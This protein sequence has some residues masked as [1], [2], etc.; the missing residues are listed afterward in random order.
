MVRIIGTTC[1][2]KIRSFFV[3]LFCKEINRRI[4]Y[5]LSNR[6]R[7][8][9]SVLLKQISRRL[10]TL[11]T[12][13]L[14][15]NIVLLSLCFSAFPVT[16]AAIAATNADAN[17]VN[18]ATGDVS[19]PVNLAT[20]PGRNGLGFGI[21]LFYT[22]NVKNIVDSWNLETPTGMAGLGWTLARD[23]IIRNTNG[24]GTFEDDDFYLLDQSGLNHFVQTNCQ[25]TN[26][27]NSCDLFFY[28]AVK[29]N[30]W[31]IE[32]NSLQEQWT[33]IKE[34]GFK[35]I[36]GGGVTADGDG[37][38]TSRGDSV[39]WNIKWNNWIGNSIQ[40][41]NQ[42]QYA[43]SWNLVAIENSW[44]DQITFSY[45]QEQELVG[46]NGAQRRKYTRSIRLKDLTDPTGHK[47]I[48]HYLDKFPD[49]YEDPHTVPNG[50]HNQKSLPVTLHSS[51]NWDSNCNDTSKWYCKSSKAD[52]IVSV[53]VN[54]VAQPQCD[55]HKDDTNDVSYSCQLHFDSPETLN[56]VRVKVIDDDQGSNEQMFDHTF[57]DV[58]CASE[59]QICTQIDGEGNCTTADPKRKYATVKLEYACTNNIA[60]PDAYQE[61]Y[62][63]HYL[64]NVK[65]YNGNEHLYTTHLNY[66]SQ[67]NILPALLGKGKFAKRLLTGISYTAPDG[68]QYAP[69]QRFSYWGQKE[70]DGVKGVKQD[71]NWQWQY[72]LFN[73]Q[74]GA[75]YGALKTVTLP[76]G[77]EIT[78]FYNQQDIPKSK[79]K[80]TIQ[81]PSLPGTWSNPRLFW[82]PDYVV[83]I[84]QKEGTQEA[85]LS[86]Y[87]WLGYWK[88]WVL[89]DQGLGAGIFSVKD[90]N[91]V[92]GGVEADFFALTTSNGIFLFHKDMLIP[93][94]WQQQN[95]ERKTLVLNNIQVASGKRFFVV[96]NEL[97]HTVYRFTWTGQSFVEDSIQ[98]SKDHT[99]FGLTSRNNYFF[100]ASANPLNDSDPELRLYSLSSQGSWQESKETVSSQFF[101]GLSDPSKS[102]TKASINLTS[103]NSFLTLQAASQ[104]ETTIN[105]ATP[106]RAELYKHY[107]SSWS[108]NYKITIQ[109][110]QS[111]RDFYRPEFNEAPAPIFTT[112]GNNLVTLADQE[113]PWIIGTHDRKDKKYTY[114]FNGSN[115]LNHEFTNDRISNNFW[116]Y[117]SI[118]TTKNGEAQYREFNPDTESWRNELPKYKDGN[119]TL[120]QKA[121]TI[122]SDV[123]TVLSMVLSEVPVVGEVMMAADL[124]F[125]VGDMGVDSLAR[126]SSL[127]GIGRYFTGDNEAYY[128]LP[129]GTWKDLGPLAKEFQN[130]ETSCKGLACVRR[131]ETQELYNQS[132]QSAN[133]FF[134]YVVKKDK[135]DVVGS[136][137]ITAPGYPKLLSK[138][139]LLKNGQF[140]GSELNFPEKESLYH[141][142]DD[143]SSLIG[144]GAF[145]TYTPK[146]LGK[147][148]LKEA[149]ALHLYRVADDNITAAPTKANGNVS[150]KELNSS[151]QDFIVSQVKIDNGSKH[152]YTHYEYQ[153]ETAVMESDGNKALYHKVTVIPSGSSETANKSNGFSE[154]YYL[155]GNPDITPGDSNA[156]F[157]TQDMVQKCSFSNGNPTCS[158]ATDSNLRPVRGLEYY[159]RVCKNNNGTCQQV[160][161]T[162]SKYQVF[163]VPLNIQ[164]LHGVFTRP[165]QISTNID[166][167]TNSTITTY[168]ANGLPSTN[169]SYQ[170]NL[171]GEKENLVTTYTYI[172]DAYTDIASKQQLQQLNLISPVVQSITTVNGVQISEN[173]STWKDWGNSKWAPFQT[174]IARNY[175]PGNFDWANNLPAAPENWL[176][177]SE[178][179]GLNTNYGVLTE[180]QN[181]DGI[182]QSVIFDTK[183]RFPIATFVAARAGSNQA[184]YYG[185]ETY[186]NQSLWKITGPIQDSVAHTGKSALS[187][188]DNI[189][190]EP[191]NFSP[192]TAN[193]PYLISAWVKPLAG[194]IC[195]V[196]FSSTQMNYSNDNAIWQ[197]LEMV[198]QT[199]NSNQKP[200]VQCPNGGQIDDARYGPV[201]VPFSAI[202]Y[203]PT[204][205][206]PTAQLGANNEVLRYVYNQQHKLI[207]VVGPDEQPISTAL[208]FFS[209]SISVN[210]S[211]VE[212]DPNS[213]LNIAAREG[214]AYFDF[215]HENTGLWNGGVVTD[216]SLSLK[217]TERST[218]TLSSIK[219]SAIRLRVVPD[220]KNPSQQIAMSV[221]NAT[222]VY[223]GDNSWEL[224]EGES[225]KAIKSANFG[226]DWLMMVINGAVLFYANGHQ[227]FSEKFVNSVSGNNITLSVMGTNEQ[228]T[229]FDDILVISHPVVS[230]TYSDGL[231]HPIQQ[232]ILESDTTVIAASTLYD[233][234]GRAAIVSKPIRL[235]PSQGL[236]QFQP[237]LATINWQT[238][239][240]GG[241][242]GSYYRLDGGGSSDDQGFP[243]IRQI[244]E[245]NPLS[246]PIAIGLPGKNF[247]YQPFT[248]A[249]PDNQNITEFDYGPN[250]QYTAPL[251]NSLG[252]ADNAQEHYRSSTKFI[253]WDNPTHIPSASITDLGGKLVG[254]QSG[255]GNAIATAGYQFD[256]DG[257]GN[258]HSTIFAPNYYANSK[259][260][261]FVTTQTHNLLNELTSQTT[262]D[263]HQTQY[264]YDDA[265]RL[266][267]LM[268]ATGAA[269]TPNRVLYWKYDNL[270]RPIETGY[271][272]QDWNTISEADLQNYSNYPATPD[273]WR[274]QYH[275]DDNQRCD[276]NPQ[277]CTKFL[278]GRLFRVSINND[279]NKEPEATETY[280]YGPFGRIHAVTNTN[281]KFP[282]KVHTIGYD[283]DR[284]GNITSID[285]GGNPKQADLQKNVTISENL[286]GKMSVNALDSIIISEHLSADQDSDITLRSGLEIGFSN[287]F[288]IYKG[289]DLKAQTGHLGHTVFYDYNQLGQL[290]SIGT[291]SEPESY[292]SYKYNA[293]GSIK[294][295]QLNNGQI[296]RNYHYDSPGWLHKIEDSYF[297]EELTYRRKNR[298]YNDANIAKTKYSFKNAIKFPSG[299]APS[300]YEYDYSYDALGRLSSANVSSSTASNINQYDLGVSKSLTYDANGNILNLSR[301]S[302]IAPN[303]TYYDGSNNTGPNQ[304]KTAADS[305]LY[306][307]DVDGKMIGRSSDCSNQNSY[308]QTLN[309][310]PFSHLTTQFS[311]NDLAVNITYGL[312]TRRLVKEVSGASSAKTLY[313]HGLNELPLMEKDQSGSDPV[314]TTY[315]IYGPTGLIA[316][317]NNQ[318]NYFFSSDY[319]GS[320]RV[321]SKGSD[322]S[323]EAYFNYTPFGELMSDNS[324]GSNADKFAYRYTG[325]EYDPEMQLYNY[326][327]RIY[328]PSLARFYV[329][330][331]AQESFGPYTY[332]GNNPIR[333]NDP[334]GSTKLPVRTA[335]KS[336]EKAAKAL[337]KGSDEASSLAKISCRFSFTAGTEISS[338]KGLRPIE[339]IKVGDMV[340]AFDE[341][342]GKTDLFPVTKLFRRTAE[343]ILTLQVGDELIEVTPEHPFFVSNIGWVKAKDLKIGDMLST[344]EG[345]TIAVSRIESRIG[346]VQVYN[347][348]VDKAHNYFV[349]NTE[350]LVHNPCGPAPNGQL[351]LTDDSIETLNDPMFYFHD[352]KGK[353]TFTGVV[354]NTTNQIHVA[355]VAWRTASGSVPEPGLFGHFFV[356]GN[357]AAPIVHAGNTLLYKQPRANSFFG[358]MRQRILGREAL[359][360][361]PNGPANT[362]TSHFQLSKMVGLEMDHHNGFPEGIGFA[363]TLID[364][365]IVRLTY[366]SNTLNLK[367]T[368]SGNAPGAWR[369]GIREA[370]E[371]SGYVIVP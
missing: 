50:A 331:P 227:L 257:A 365:Q 210:N 84:W 223:K 363:A 61:R 251:F 206:L 369:D 339:E 13:T 272:S 43:S 268:N 305:Q 96:L 352:G 39:E 318:D 221:G 81:K 240:M 99:V 7:F 55:Y 313:L 230:V 151:L 185:F 26:F 368:G 204:T 112:D 229:L 111:I 300:N 341:K 49:E 340:L 108:E 357:T 203:D 98:L 273:S 106:V 47:A 150:S 165:W 110:L 164:Q 60:E 138:I 187:G 107:I 12:P 317:N 24:T 285:Y 38:K 282:D 328:D 200:F 333:F 213:I 125:F 129:N 154:H 293:D 284:L 342:A 137:V 190:I 261:I 312:G 299:I 303:Y 16:H 113:E 281:T 53:W 178:I 367:L 338:A 78:Y 225:I 288:T 25:D 364:E 45:K 205:L 163:T 82:G 156:P 148:N 354:D 361:H 94:K 232:Q 58:T 127:S 218:L 83:V 34:D 207:A 287:D 215:E 235:V 183:Y 132:T 149:T 245:S 32:Y 233:N 191:S 241:S 249:I 171:A 242:V 167:A 135:R 162:R 186:E 69:P 234:L 197:H 19:F 177:T 311:K 202:I 100:T 182:Y 143:T 278:K 105:V 267:F 115:W 72:D 86:V 238:G 101:I 40:A 258:S 265:G 31:H 184:G 80:L 263:S 68:S 116:G 20:L 79:R 30:P 252:I 196:G 74:T 41:D 291:S 89:P 254:Q 126:G 309:Y 275:Y 314:N 176:K 134:S 42:T 75:L 231:G 292:A 114:R 228:N 306:C 195:K 304:V 70:S 9:F 5:W 118:T 264:K 194:K 93:G 274:Q 193:T 155:N 109:E 283:Y 8:K 140:F 141:D 174:Y 308:T 256:F 18:L 76:E 131:I 85:H 247:A 181:V 359:L 166:G 188:S 128:L 169:S 295:E 370:F 48:L 57:E 211:L 260:N 358:R 212:N 88:S 179:T 103:A 36:Y 243:Y 297:V 276:T 175:N 122:A 219:N 316:S 337:S 64:S 216:G 121:W 298:R 56:S 310:D 63:T 17:N 6:S 335:L 296:I 1:T 237:D 71:E 29:Y 51:D 136:K 172:Q 52:P 319:L 353:R 326:R 356:N 325:Q 209:R 248:S 289:A 145:I 91:L 201:N 142:H 4:E 152:I 362:M 120:F 37:N 332:V 255:S 366:H 336:E 290:V 123:E 130:T 259:N 180:T 343:K 329:P 22:S 54:G 266:R 14:L 345:E 220:S 330:D 271:F 161:D 222:I 117:D 95:I 77:G 350:V 277:T 371:N 323:V 250:T 236:L 301:G 246:R 334:T 158:N 92:K 59:P 346:A 280:R 208:N 147:P 27:D 302:S 97:L 23:K 217:G 28:E 33:I 355:P 133:N 124:A 347:F 270:G 87:Q 360:I 67:D 3:K 2:I 321:V 144:S 192:T 349:S 168:N 198:T 214:G 62:G 199:P 322:G 324:G 307:Y 269:Q 244:F 73:A 153:K 35:Y 224:L 44:G 351:R 10:L 262:P 253:P 104:E 189:S 15:T 315:Y 344:A 327:A 239:H 21:N 146:N 159:T 286:N 139:R 119:P 90:I 279:D 348:E 157:L 160:A 65:I 226:Q 66:K 46:S 102:N 170:Y 11:L 173:I 320:V 294:T